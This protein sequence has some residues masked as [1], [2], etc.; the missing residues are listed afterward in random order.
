VMTLRSYL[1]AVRNAVPHGGNRR[2][3]PTAHQ[4]D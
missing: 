4:T 3:R 1:F 2:W